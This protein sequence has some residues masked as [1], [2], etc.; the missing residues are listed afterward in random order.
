M[1]YSSLNPNLLVK[2]IEHLRLRINERFAERNIVKVCAELKSHAEQAD[3]RA[4]WISR[5]ILSV[6]IS[7][8]GLLLLLILTVAYFIWSKLQFTEGVVQFTE[9]IQVFEAGINAAVL[10]GAGIFFLLQSERRIKRQRTLDALHELRSLAH[11]VD[12][13]QLTKDPEHVLGDGRSTE[14]SPQSTLTLFEL[15]RYLD[16]CSEMLALIGKVAALY[17]QEFDDE[18]AVAAVNEIE[19]LTSGLSRKI[20]QKIMYV[21]NI[22]RAMEGQ[23]T[24]FNISMTRTEISGL[25][26]PQ[27]IPNRKESTNHKEIPGEK[28]NHEEIT[29][30]NE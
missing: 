9:T 7:I 14:H 13:H 1:P 26:A 20:W 16:Y 23:D 21:H 22:D 18:V 30:K 8:A 24:I 11:V 10:S 28:T 2:Q 25:S 27:P 19:D 6:R 17:V 12:M 3:A 5:P 4:G 15:T 29:E